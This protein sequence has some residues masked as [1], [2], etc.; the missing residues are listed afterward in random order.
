VEWLETYPDL[1]IFHRIMISADWEKAHS[2]GNVALNQKN[3]GLWRYL[4]EPPYFTEMGPE[5]LVKFIEFS[6]TISSEQVATE[7]PVEEAEGTALDLNTL[8][9]EYLRL[10]KEMEPG[11]R[12]TRAMTS[13]VTKM[14]KAMAVNPPEEDKVQDWLRSDDD[15]QRLLGI[16][17]LRHTPQ[18]AMYDDL[19]NIVSGS[20]SA[21]EQYQ[22]LLAM[23]RIAR[24]M[25]DK[26]QQQQ[27]IEVLKKQLDF[28]PGLK[29]WLEPGS[30]RASIAER[31]LSRMT[32]EHTAS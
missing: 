12:R 28:N 15:G 4:K 29:Q 19:V 14:D 10:R 8:G 24:R 13:I 23:E 18:V 7:P 11:T 20:R 27:L 3:P 32:D 25:Q 17:Y 22:A 26:L 21:F 2:I 9:M 31:I 16:T 6:G 1:K 5:Q 30:D